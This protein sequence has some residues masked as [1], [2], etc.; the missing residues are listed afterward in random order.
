MK[1]L[2]RCRSLTTFGC[3]A[4][5]L[6]YKDSTS[7]TLAGG[8]A[9]RTTVQRGAILTGIARIAVGVITMEIGENANGTTTTMDVGT[10]TAIATSRASRRCRNVL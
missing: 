5:G 7:G 2:P 6:P 3:P 10:L 1:S 4:T 8:I 9:P